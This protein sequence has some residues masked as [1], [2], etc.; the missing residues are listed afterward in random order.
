[1]THVPGHT[2]EMEQQG[3]T[4]DIY[5]RGQQLTSQGQGAPAT[6]PPAGTRYQTVEGGI[7][8]TWIADGH[9]SGTLDP[10]QP[11]RRA[12]TAPP[13]QGNPGSVPE[14]IGSDRAGRWRRNPQTGE[15]DIPVTAPTTV[16]TVPGGPAGTLVPG[17]DAQGNPTFTPIPGTQP[18]PPKP[19]RA[20]HTLP[21]GAIVIVD[22]DT[23]E[24]FRTGIGP[25]PT[26]AETNELRNWQIRSQEQRANAQVGDTRSNTQFNQTVDL[27]KLENDL[28]TQAHNR[29]VD[30][31]KNEVALNVD[32][33]MKQDEARRRARADQIAEAQN[34][35]NA[36][37]RRYDIGRKSGQEAV[38]EYYKHAPYLLPAGFGA[39]LAATAQGTGTFN[40][41]ALS[42]PAPDFNAMRNQAS[43]Q[44]LSQVP[45]Y[46]DTVAQTPYQGHAQSDD[47]QTA[48]LL[49]WLYPDYRPQTLAQIWA[50]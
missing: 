42:Q 44:A 27:A 22:M 12:D 46:A 11:P 48:A 6:K 9:G 24:V 50:K 35:Q 23:G 45:Q 21:S 4:A 2:R 17:Q 29:D 40:L 47:E 43:Q 13:A 33:P 19:N 16:Q 8:Y 20:Q 18:A 3:I 25:D 5:D 26:V 14:V 34:T 32:L 49:K 38:D 15:Y 36:A 37:E 41:G 39:N 31:Y 10:Q 1:M 28:N 30:R 7:I